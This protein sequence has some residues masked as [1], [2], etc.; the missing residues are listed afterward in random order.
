MGEQFCENCGK[1]N[2]EDATYCY[3]CGHILPVGLAAIATHSLGSSDSLHP[4]IR[5]GTAY[6]GEQSVLRVHVRHTGAMFEAKFQLE[7][8]LGRTAGDVVVDVDLTPYGAV[9][10]GVSRQHAK[11]TRQDATI[12]VQDLGSINGTFLNGEKLIAHQPRV[13]RNEDELILGQMALRI[14]FMRSPHLPGPA[15]GR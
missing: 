2:T 4:Q 1:A 6:F 8:I 15:V 9:D 5:W 3:A 13:L 7:C 10:L 12:M 11:L 14:S